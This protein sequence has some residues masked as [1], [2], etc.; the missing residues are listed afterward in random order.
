MYWGGI[1]SVFSIKYN[2]SLDRE[3]A[4]KMPPFL[5]VPKMLLILFGTK[6]RRKVE[7]AGQYICRKCGVKR[8]YEV[9][10]LREWVTFFYTYSSNSK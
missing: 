4:Q 1:Y 6:D 5:I 9:I 3:G 8:D 7:G 2:G 10:S